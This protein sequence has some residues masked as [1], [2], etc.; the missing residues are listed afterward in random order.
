MVVSG[1]TRQHRWVRVVG[2]GDGGDGWLMEEVVVAVA[3][4]IKGCCSWSKWGSVDGSVMLWE[5]VW[6]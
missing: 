1:L 6:W 4:V 3:V 5:G 2:E